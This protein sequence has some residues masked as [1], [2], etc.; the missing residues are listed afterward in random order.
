MTPETEREERMEK[1]TIQK[2]DG[3]LL[4]FYRFPPEETECQS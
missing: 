2:E 4:T 1:T 3:R